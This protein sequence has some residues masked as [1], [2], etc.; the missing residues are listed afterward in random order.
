LVFEQKP[1]AGAKKKKKGGGCA[2][3]PTAFKGLPG[4]G[5]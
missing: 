3:V 2:G 1:A 5:V 4:G